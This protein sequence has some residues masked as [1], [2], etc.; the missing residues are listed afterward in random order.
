MT[1]QTSPSRKSKVVMRVKKSNSSGTALG[2]NKTRSLGLNAGII[3]L[4]ID[5]FRQQLMFPPDRPRREY[6]HLRTTSRGATHIRAS[7]RALLTSV[8]PVA[9]IR[10][11]TTAP[12][13]VPSCQGSPHRPTGALDLRH[14]HY[15]LQRRAGHRS[16]K[17]YRHGKSVDMQICHEAGGLP[18]PMGPAA[19]S[20]SATV[21]FFLTCE[22]SRSIYLFSSPFPLQPSG[23]SS[24]GV[25]Y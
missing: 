18:V 14:V 11:R 21:S 1:S 22:C 13:A 20:L 2:L 12:G 10:A 15:R 24:M 4:R 5:P 16:L 25:P 6:W 17:G 8:T 23:L 19:G 3:P 7:W 9:S